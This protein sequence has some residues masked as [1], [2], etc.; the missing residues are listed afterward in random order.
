[1]LAATA[2]PIV[3]SSSTA[4]ACAEASTAHVGVAT[5]SRTAAQLLMDAA[6]VVETT[7]PA[8][9]ATGLCTAQEFLT[10]AARV[11]AAIDRVAVRVLSHV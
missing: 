10:A 4:A 7:R 6:F 3:D 5:V 9:V 1:M 11:A 2:L 8:E